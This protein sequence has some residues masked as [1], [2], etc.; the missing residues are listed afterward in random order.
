MK[1]IKMIPFEEFKGDRK[2][3]EMLSE[4]DERQ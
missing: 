4:R 2:S 3:F 1:D